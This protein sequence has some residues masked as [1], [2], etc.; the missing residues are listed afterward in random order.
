MK[1]YEAL[2]HAFLMEGVDTHFCLLG[3]GNLHWGMALETGGARTLHAR[4][5]HCAVAMAA[6]YASATGRTGIAS[7]TCGPG[8]T[9]VMTALASAARDRLPLVVFAGESPM[10]ARWWIQDIDQRPL[11]V[12]CGA[13]YIAVHSPGL[14]HYQVQEAFCFA[15]RE[16]KPVVV[17]VPYDLQQEEMPSV[18][19]Y[20]TSD[21]IL[22]ELAPVAPDEE[23]AARVAAKLR[24]ARCPLIIA[25]RGVLAARGENEVEALA[26]LCGALLGTTLPAR[27]MFDRNPFSLGVIGGYSRMIAREFVAKADLVVAFGASLSAFT[28]AGGK[29][30]NAE[31]IQVDIHPVGRR[32]GLKVADLYMRAD[33]RLA[34]QA[35]GRRLGNGEDVRSSI[36]SAQLAARIRDEPADDA[37][38]PA[39]PGTVDPRAAFKELERLIPG[40]FDVVS[41]SG[42]QAYF[43]TVMR[44]YDARKYHC[45]REFGAIGNA[46]SYGVGIAAARGN[47]GK[48][49]VFDGDGGVLMH[50]Q[51]LECIKRHGL[52]MLI[53]LCNDG[54]YGAELHHLRKQ[55]LDDAI[56]TFGRPNFADIA[57]GFGLE[58]AVVTDVK[59]L[60]GLAQSYLDGTTTAI[61]D[62]H[63]NDKVMNPSYRLG[64]KHAN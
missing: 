19:P 49:V 18:A 38:F 1:L 28:Q 53:V 59:Q 55:G 20:E 16:R 56:V 25:G 7:V 33:A 21:A 22:P 48:V 34:A 42:H 32:D 12:A 24:N 4:H 62:I 54:A 43:H 5:E 45:L 8:F 40:D 31:V 46:L 13:H 10:H 61:W 36:R 9:Q 60:S 23:A 58:G 57:R 51:E 50:I 15:K 39:Q 52:K 6:G 27:G 14:A 35:I 30:V 17:G 47:N 37:V 44:G 26:D 2:A 63:V 41:G 64:S 29:F 3:D 11:A